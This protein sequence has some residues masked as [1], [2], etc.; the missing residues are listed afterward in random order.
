MNLITL[1]EAAC[2]THSCK[3]MFGLCDDPHPSKNPAYID[4]DNGMKW[5]AVVV[6]ETLFEVTFT[7][8]DH[9]IDTKKANGNMDKRCDGALT[10]HSTVIF[11]ELKERT[12]RGNEWVV[13]AAKQL[14][15]SIRNFEKHIGS[16]D[17]PVKKAYIANK[18][19]PKFKETQST[20]MRRFQDETGYTLRIENRIILS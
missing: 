10:F 7:A 1:Q 15:S 4:E 19:R 11:V 8:I 17:Y 6:N 9:C 16:D 13:E 20:R 5:I 3:S 14:Q 12:S 2:Q 18:D